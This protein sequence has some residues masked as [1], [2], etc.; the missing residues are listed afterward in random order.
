ML[1]YLFIVNPVAGKNKG[2]KVIPIIEKIMKKEQLLYEIILT[3]KIGE[4]EEIAAE[5]VGKDFST[6]VAVGGDGTIHEVLNGMAG[7]DKILGIIPAGTGNDLG[8]TLN[9]PKKTEAALE[10]ILKGKTKEI[11][12][13]RMRDKYFI[14]FAS[15]GLDAVIASEANSIKKYFSGR[16][17]YVV[18]ALKG[19]TT[20][21]SN[22]LQFIIDDK[23]FYC[24]VLMITLCNGIYYGGG[25]KVAPKA[26]LQDGYFD[27]CVI[28]NINKLKLLLLFPTIFWGKHTGYK[29]VDFYKGKK[30]QIF[31]EKP[32]QIN[33][34]GE[35][36]DVESLEFEVAKQKLKVIVN[37]P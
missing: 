15:I 5:A 2:K 12:L 11:D 26:D 28:K 1:A 20:F 22:K 23:K 37:N 7:S 24:D 3:T 14:N 6:I 25:M 27:I 10:M 32:L 8:R 19:I 21:K 31:A 9:L 35:I 4:A 30:V 18:A 34:D 33:A 13:G 16:F 29:E 36:T 17:A